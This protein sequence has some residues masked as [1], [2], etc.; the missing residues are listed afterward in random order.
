MLRFG[1]SAFLLGLPVCV[2]WYRSPLG[3]M[4]PGAF[5]L[6]LPVASVVGYRM[7]G[8]ILGWALLL[9]AAYLL[10]GGYY[11]F[12]L[13]PSRRRQTTNEVNEIQL[14]VRGKPAQVLIDR[15]GQP[16]ARHPQHGGAEVWKWE[17]DWAKG[18]RTAQ[19]NADGSV[20]DVEAR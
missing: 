10:V 15:W 5:W 6:I 17:A 8:R 19:V 12:W 16:D 18:K 2:L 4:Y 11:L 20:L 1:V 9:A 14:T 3:T 13:D 7:V